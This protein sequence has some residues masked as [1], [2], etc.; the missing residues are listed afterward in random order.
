M[1]ETLWEREDELAA[2]SAALARAHSGRGAVLLLRGEPG[3]GKTRLLQAASAS[4][5]GSF[6][7]VPAGGHE[8]ERSY[9]YALAQQVLEGILTHYGSNLEELSIVPDSLR[10]LLHRSLKPAG[11][12]LAA[13][14]ELTHAFC[15]LLGSVAERR[16]L[17]L[18]LDDLHWSDPDSLELLHFFLRRIDLLPVAVLGATRPWPAAASGL[19]V[20]LGLDT[21]ELQPLS[22]QGCAALLGNR[23]PA[24]PGS[25]TLEEA[26]ALTKG[27]P[28]LLEELA[29]SLAT[30]TGPLP[31]SRRSL[32][33]GRLRG[34]PPE[35]L[36]L[37]EAASIL[38]SSFAT[39]QASELAGMT[40]ADLEE[41]LVPLRELGLLAPR[42]GGGLSFN[43]PL[44]RHSC[45]ESLPEATRRAWHRRAADL[46]RLSGARA[47]LLAPH[48]ELGASPGD[49][50]ASLL[51][52]EAAREA[53]ATGAHGAAV[54]HLE[55]A[56]ELEPPFPFKAKL[57]FDLGHAHLGCDSPPRAAD[58]FT[59]AA[60]LAETDLSFKCRIRRSL[61]VA[62]VLGGD[63]A[64]ARRQLELAVAEAKISHPAA[65]LRAAFERFQFERIFGTIETAASAIQEAVA[66]GEASADTRAQ[67]QIR[68]AACLFN[69]HL[70]DPDAFALA[71]E[72]V[73]R[74]SPSDAD[75]LEPIWGWSPR[76]LLG[77]I[78]GRTGKYEEA[79]Q[80]LYTAVASWKDSSFSC[81]AAWAGAYLSEL[82]YRRGRLREAYRHAA[83]ATTPAVLNFPMID[84]WASHLHARILGDLGDLDAAEVALCRAEE[85]ARQ[86][87]TPLG[88]ALCRWTRATLASR[89]EQYGLAFQLFLAGEK[90]DWASAPSPMDFNWRLEAVEVCLQTKRLPE[91]RR[92]LTTVTQAPA[93]RNHRGV[94]SS[95]Q[96]AYGLLREAEGK[97]AESEAAF[98]QALTLGRET[99]EALEQGRNLLAYGAYLRRRGRSKEARFHLDEALLAFRACGSSLWADRAENERHLAGGRRRVGYAGENR[100]ELLT[101][102][103]HR[104]AEFLA[105]GRSNREIAYALF[106]SP[107]TLETHL[108]NIYR[109]LA[110]SS[111][112]EVGVYFSGNG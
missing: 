59:Q 73:S 45:Y 87:S 52:G 90:E 34:L 104:I 7:V 92:L 86:S 95:I 69:S 33:L 12:G 93:F 75:E 70:G 99:D 68:S 39:S 4:A 57:L 96:R 3:L 46:L 49:L 61:A 50:N 82:E 9:P 94:Q 35:S 78:A 51:L 71:Q 77:I 25:P 6:A 23:L 54:L 24:G 64:A 107:K 62:L 112:Q 76:F 36:R 109:K 13:K 63:P 53:T 60:A 84:A 2:I 58:A 98:R 110:I 47:S 30:G 20:S 27:V 103:E 111:R 18:C 48:L 72:A 17:L 74:L 41:A 56:L 44:L 38:G 66:L 21:L 105:Q 81:A 97:E 1:S 80:I 5:T 85:S 10:L 15:W 100:L 16:P 28:F 11:N 65:A 22:P 106:I 89:R 79:V 40:P 8:L 32:I 29:D 55:K 91:A 37:L 102:Q 14:F 88:L 108:R 43:H 67:A 31:S 42:P 83:A 19:A 26:F 101:P